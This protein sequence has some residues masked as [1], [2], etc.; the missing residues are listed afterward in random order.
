MDTGKKYDDRFVG[1][2]RELL[3][4][5]EAGRD[6]EAEVIVGEITNIHETEMF[7][8][9]GKLTRE[10]HSALAG[11]KVDN[12]IVDIAEHDI[13]DAKERLDYVIR[14]T[15]QAA[16][17]TLSAVEESIPLCEELVQRTG[18][19]AG[20]W[21]RFMARDM[22]A[23]RFRSLVSDI[24]GYLDGANAKCTA[25]KD[26]LNDVLIA[27]DFQ[28]L[29]GQTIRKVIKLV[30]DV[31]ES[32]VGFIRVSSGRSADRADSAGQDHRLSGPQIPGREESGAMKNQDEVDELLSSLG[33]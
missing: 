16:H 26:H 8:E 19:I 3:G 17:K 33:F 32:L 5:L 2:V 4:H 11:F 10:L 21:R 12:R 23:E 1:R 25:I 22:D 6:E 15:E 31:E 13:P 18:K 27:Q 24:Q 29:T 14:M 7:K 20:E 28:D 30:Q 9:L